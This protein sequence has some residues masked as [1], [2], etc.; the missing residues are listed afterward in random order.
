MS[1]CKWEHIE[2][3]YLGHVIGQEKLKADEEKVTV[4]QQWEKPQT[5]KDLQ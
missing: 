4:I 2:V 1:K 3:E 5:T